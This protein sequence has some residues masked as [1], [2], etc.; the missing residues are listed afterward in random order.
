MTF[1][2]QKHKAF[3]SPEQQSRIVNAIQTAEQQTSGEVRV[4]VESRCSYVDAL[5]RA[6]ELFFNLKMDTTALHNAVLVYVAVKDKQVALFADAGIHAKTG[7][8]YWQ[9]TVEAMLQQFGQYELVDGLVRSI[10]H[11]GDALQQHFP[12]DKTTDKNELP[13]DIVFGK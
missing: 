13:D 5:D 7:N 12:Y 10:L 11:I 6:K 3:F 9:T 4:F 2:W 1:P 8:S